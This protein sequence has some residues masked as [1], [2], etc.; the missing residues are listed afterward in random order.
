MVGIGGALTFLHAILC[1]APSE[2]PNSGRR[3]KHGSVEPPEKGQETKGRTPKKRRSHETILSYSGPLG[4]KL[5]GEV[6]PC[7]E[8]RATGDS[9]YPGSGSSPGRTGVA[10]MGGAHIH[11]GGGPRRSQ[12]AVD[13]RC[14]PRGR[15]R[16]SGVPG[17]GGGEPDQPGDRPAGGQHLGLLRGAS[18]Y[19]PHRGRVA[20]RPG[21][22]LSS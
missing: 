18:P 4:H 10:A 11:C 16:R 20:P 12:R 3:R 14:G 8:E 9:G 7:E 1:P 15:G 5:K 19:A 22:G 13:R 17:R 2:G 21:F 6:G